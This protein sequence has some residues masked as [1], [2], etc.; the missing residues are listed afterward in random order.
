MT[1][2]VLTVGGIQKNFQSLTHRHGLGEPDN[3]E[4]PL[5]TVDPSINFMDEVL[6][7][8]DGEPIFNGLVEKRGLSDD[9]SGTDMVLRGR[10]YG[11]KLSY[12]TL[13][14][15]IFTK[16]E[17]A[18]AIR[19]LLRPTIEVYSF[20]DD[21]E[22]AV[23]NFEANRG[24][25][26]YQYGVLDA[27]DNQ[28]NYKML[29]V[30]TATGAA[31]WTNYIVKAHVCPLSNYLGNRLNWS[32]VMCGVVGGYTDVNNFIF[33][34][35]G[36]DSSTGK[37][38]FYLYK[39]VADVTT[40]LASC[41]FDWSYLT[42]YTIALQLRGTTATAFIDGQKRLTGTI[43]SGFNTG[44]AGL[45]AGGSHCQFDNFWVSLSGKTATASLNSATAINA[46]DGDLETKWSSGQAQANGQWFKFDLGAAKTICRVTFIQDVAN[47]AKNYKIELAGA[48]ENYSQ[49]LSRT[50]DYRPV[51][52]FIFT[53]TSA[54]YI[55]ITITA[56]NSAQ[57]DIFEV[58]AHEAD[59]ERILE[60][61]TIDNFGTPL[62]TEMKHENRL[63]AAF[64]I[65]EVCGG[66]FWVGLDKK[67]NFKAN[68]GTDK[69]ATIKFEYGN[70]IHS[71]NREKS[72]EPG[73]FGNNIILLGH[74]EGDD[75]LK[76]EAKDQGSINE[77]GQV[78]MPIIEQDLMALATLNQRAQILLD[79]Y[80]TPLDRITFFAKEIYGSLAYGPGDKVQVTHVKV[81]AGAAYWINSVTRTYD[82]NAET[83]NAEL[84]NRKRLPPKE[85][86]E[87]I[88][89][90]DRAISNVLNY[91][92]PIAQRNEVQEVNGL[93][94]VGYAYAS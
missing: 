51:I 50:S 26:A 73:D 84:S 1:T 27:L 28:A 45:I 10:D 44:K 17:P 72:I 83:V 57:W 49:I 38:M 4:A 58:G 62:T 78:D 6:I 87:I 86:G 56:S 36:Y 70:N 30:T 69:S 3:F 19:A 66:E 80:K 60:E 47:F 42:T 15:T 39:V 37:R 29:I 40:V 76:V 20:K 41:E 75:Q 16:T 55:K 65:A 33:A 25:A 23:S 59:G 21:F 67:A 34:A 32:N 11:A 63:Q 22:G 77:Y 46:L 12:K 2:F 93:R 89:E 31:S 13:I 88:A 85:G 18:D 94:S 9:S 92:A 14:E 24:T 81:Q 53:P 82:G 54:R 5:R 68:R 79:Y 35:L 52:D 90:L 91:P 71:I 74:G 48:D 7:L 64:R 43:P 61:G 8:R